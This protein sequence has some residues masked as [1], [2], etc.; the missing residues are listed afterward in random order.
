M[1][2][3]VEDEAVEACVG[4]E[5][6]AAAAEGEGG[7]VALSGESEG[8]E[9]GG[10]VG[11]AGE[12]AGGAAD[13]EGGKGRERDVLLDLEKGAGHRLRIRHSDGEEGGG[14]RGRTM[15]GRDGRF[16]DWLRRV[17]CIQRLC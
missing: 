6:V 15:E 14:G 10:L 8:F 5:E 4:D 13:A 16:M 17:L 1:D 2:S 12:V 11:D 3:E 9:E 7:E